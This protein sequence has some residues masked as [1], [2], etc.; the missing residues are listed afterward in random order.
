M[1]S[2]TSGEIKEKYDAIILFEKAGNNYYYSNPWLKP[3]YEFNDL[4][5][6]TGDDPNVSIGSY[7]YLDIDIS[8]W[9]GNLHASIRLR[10]SSDYK[11][12]IR[13]M[14]VDKRMVDK[15]LSWFDTHKSQI[16]GGKLLIIKS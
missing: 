3:E 12:P 16:S 5:F 15:F 1:K 4:I 8:K 9:D 14:M 13:K 11:N 2:L 10:G 7:S 6:S